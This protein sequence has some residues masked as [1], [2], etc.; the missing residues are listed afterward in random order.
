MPKTFSEAETIS[1]YIHELVR[2]RALKAI[3]AHDDKLSK[4]FDR[5]AEGVR[6]DLRASGY[7]VAEVRSI[8]EKHFGAESEARLKIIEDSI[9]DAA[10]EARTLDRETFEA[11]FGAE[12]VAAAGLPLDPPSAPMLTLLPKHPSES[13]EE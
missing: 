1:R 12:E 8:L 9:R 2:R 5:I 10:R 6:R 7:T 3:A 11:I 13:G 4:V